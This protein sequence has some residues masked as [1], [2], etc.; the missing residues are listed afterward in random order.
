MP[1][2]R[3]YG[4][5]RTPARS[6]RSSSLARAAIEPGGVGVGRPAVRGVVLEAAVAGWV[7]RRG[8]HDAV[9]EAGAGRAAAVR[10][11][12]RVRDRGRRG[13]AVGRVDE[14]RDVVADQDLDRAHP[15]RF[16]EAVRVPAEEQR[17]V[18]TL[19][20]AVLADGLGGG[21]DVRLVERRVEAR[22]AMAGGAERDLLARIL[23]IGSDREVGRHEVTDVDQVLRAGRLA[24]ACM[25]HDPILAP[26]CAGAPSG[27]GVRRLGR[28]PARASLL[29]CAASWGTSG[30]SRRLTWSWT[31]CAGWSTAATTRPVWRSWPMA[32]SSARSARA[33]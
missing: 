26:R 8:D 15:G 12:D 13:E 27:P 2:A 7:V 4:I 16:G 33:S 3:A 14:H 28:P 24:R 19:R 18:V 6:A 5:R 17:S 22:A 21:Q 1:R 29:V 31:G 20:G 11:Q 23:G 25:R 30:R 32:R 10:A 9:R